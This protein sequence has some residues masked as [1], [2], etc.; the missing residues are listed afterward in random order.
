[1]TDEVQADKNAVRQLKIKTGTLKRQLKDYTFYKKE[2][3]QLQEKLQQMSQSG[4]DSHD[5]NKM[6]ESVNETTEVLSTCKPRI[7]TAMED[8]EGLLATYTDGG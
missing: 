3:G 1:M 7:D 5:I 4:A 8:L 2:E 6:T